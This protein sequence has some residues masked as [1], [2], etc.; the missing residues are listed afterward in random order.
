MSECLVEELSKLE[1]VVLRHL[2]TKRPNVI[3]AYCDGFKLA[4]VHVVTNTIF[5]DIL[6]FDFID[7]L[8]VVL[9]QPLEL[10]VNTVLMFLHDFH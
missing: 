10:E 4:G 7:R 6:K 8:K 3:V 9:L 5:L 1:V 2:L